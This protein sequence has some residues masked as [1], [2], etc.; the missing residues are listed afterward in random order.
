MRSL[1]R[2][3]VLLSL[4]FISGQQDLPWELLSEQTDPEP[5]QQQQQQQQQEQQH[6]PNE[7][8]EKND[9]H[10]KKF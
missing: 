7:K 10:R 1:P 2:F 4:V 6:Q 9:K 3:I 8:G 5:Q